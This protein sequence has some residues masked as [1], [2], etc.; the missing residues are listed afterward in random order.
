[1]R[2][3]MTY[4]NPLKEGSQ[5]VSLTLMNRNVSKGSVYTSK[6]NQSGMLDHLCFIQIYDKICKVLGPWQDQIGHNYVT[7]T[8]FQ[9]FKIVSETNVL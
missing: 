3:K 5:V 9:T 8:K 7:V 4:Q 2:L 6:L 1:M